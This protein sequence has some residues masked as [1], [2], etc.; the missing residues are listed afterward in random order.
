MAKSK[1]ENKVMSVDITNNIK[2]KGNVK[3]KVYK[4]DKLCKTIE[5]HNT[6]TADLCKFLRDSIVG[7]ST[8][9]DQPSIIKPC[10]FISGSL[11]P[12][13]NQGVPF[14]SRWRGSDS[15]TDSTAV[16]KF[17]IPWTQ[18]SV[19]RKIW[20]FQLFNKNQMMHAYIKLDTPIEIYAQTNIEVEWSLKIS[21][22]N[23]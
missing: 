8:T 20:G 2:S 21:F 23:N 14:V 1:K 9:V 15:D 12:I 10:D 6:G 3:I 11:V 7:L 18:L 13:S 16:I 19:N 17:I 4:G 5:K 22:V